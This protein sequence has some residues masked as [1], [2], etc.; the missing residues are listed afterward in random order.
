M[1]HLTAESILMEP[2]VA[3]HADEMF[4]GLSD[5]PL[6]SIGAFK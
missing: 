2:Q 3:A 5:R 1:R 4:V 6:L